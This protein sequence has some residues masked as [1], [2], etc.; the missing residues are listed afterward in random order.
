[1]RARLKRQR[2][3]NAIKSDNCEALAG[4]YDEVLKDLG[5]NDKFNQ[6]QVQEVDF[7]KATEVDLDQMDDS[8]EKISLELEKRLKSIFKDVNLMNEKDYTKWRAYVDN[9]GKKLTN[10]YD[11]HQATLMIKVGHI[12]TVFLKALEDERIAQIAPKL[13]SIVDGYRA[14]LTKDADNKAV[15]NARKSDPILDQRLTHCDQ[16]K[17]ILDDKD[18]TI[19]QKLEEYETKLNAFKAYHNSIISPVVDKSENATKGFESFF[20]ACKAALASIKKS[21]PDPRRIFSFFKREKCEKR[22]ISAGEMFTQAETVLKTT[23]PK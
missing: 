7:S 1:M 12:V 16:L 21:P 4:L 10:S 23:K 18:L 2:V 6:G 9:I 19:T 14:S 17:L 11:E 13:G 15:E 20:K 22:E 8:Q 3:L 5:L